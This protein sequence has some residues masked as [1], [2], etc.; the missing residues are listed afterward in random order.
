LYG[1]YNWSKA[2]GGGPSIGSQI[3]GLFI[4]TFL[5][6][7]AWLY[8]LFKQSFIGSDSG[9]VSMSSGQAHLALDADAISAAQKVV[10]SG[11][12][13]FIPAGTAAG[14]LAFV[15][16]IGLV[17]FI[18]GV[19]SLKDV[20]DARGQNPVLSPVVKIIGGVICMNITWFGCLVSS[21]LGIPALCTGG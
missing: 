21:L 10:E 8:S 18:S 15:F 1:I 17:A 16:F 6:S 9:G 20:G 4:G 2:G 11:F 14:I 19:Y 5:I 3:G 12:G 13:K 7:L